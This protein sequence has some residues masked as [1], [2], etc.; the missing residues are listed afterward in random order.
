[1]IKEEESRKK[2]LQEKVGNA[3]FIINEWR[4]NF[5]IRK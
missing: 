4:D 5:F 1:M 3:K 2:I